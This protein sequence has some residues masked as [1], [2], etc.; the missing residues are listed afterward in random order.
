M[1]L[2]KSSLL[3]SS[4]SNTPTASN[5]DSS[6]I[7][8]NDKGYSDDVQVNSRSSPPDNSSNSIEFNDEIPNISN[9]SLN[10]IGLA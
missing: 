7:D 9:A 3:T 4:L 6:D 10:N 5:V 8:S 2:K 1:S